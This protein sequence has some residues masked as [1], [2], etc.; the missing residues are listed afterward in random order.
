MKSRSTEQFYFF[1]LTEYVYIYNNNYY[2]L[3]SSV[4]KFFSQIVLGKNIPI[5]TSVH[6]GLRIPIKKDCAALNNN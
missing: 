5:V 1:K 6:D 4:T 2:I 3:K